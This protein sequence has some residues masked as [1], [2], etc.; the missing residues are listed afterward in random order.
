M[1]K[2]FLF[3]L[4]PLTFLGQETSN[5]GSLQFHHLGFLVGPG[6]VSDSDNTLTF[7][8]EA[9]MNLDKHLFKGAW[10]NGGPTRTFWDSEPY[11]NFTEINLLYGREFSISEEFSADVYAGAGYFLFGKP[12][13]YGSRYTI[14]ESSIGFPIEGSL[15]YRIWD[16]LRLGFQAHHNFNS[17]KNVTVFGGILDFRF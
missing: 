9:V 10:V 13:P 1:K 17:V 6:I 12:D 8:F 7:N 15:K 2:L 5:D 14:N 16:W 3:L 4:I 11:G